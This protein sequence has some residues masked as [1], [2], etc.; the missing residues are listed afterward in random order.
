MRHLASDDRSYSARG[1]N[2]GQV[3]GEMTCNSAKRRVTDFDRYLWGS[4]RHRLFPGGS[5]G[6]SKFA[7]FG[8][9]EPKVMGSSPIGRTKSPNKLQRCGHGRRASGSIVVS[10]S[11]TLPETSSNRLTHSG[12]PVP[13]VQ[14]SR[15]RSDRVPAM[16]PL[17][18]SIRKR[19]FARPPRS[20]ALVDADSRSAAAEA[21]EIWTRNQ[22]LTRMGRCRGRYSTLGPPAVALERRAHAGA[23]PTTSPSPGLGIKAAR[24]SAWSWVFGI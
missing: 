23:L 19:R 10:R 11:A 18:A 13:R 12:R 17:S 9:P 22:P 4:Q 7:G 15:R 5:R 1:T 20:A 2:R 21:R 6:L 14:V 24:K 16:T 8:A 3:L